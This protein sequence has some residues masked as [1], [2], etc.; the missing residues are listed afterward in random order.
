MAEFNQKRTRLAQLYLEGLEDISG[1]DLPQIPEYD[2]I[3]AW[4][5]FVIKV[6]ALNRDK[7]MNRLSDYN[8]GYG[9]HFPPTHA[10]SYV[11]EKYAPSIGLLPETE[12]AADKIISL[13]LFPDMQDKDAEYVCK[14]IKEIMK[15]G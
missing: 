9:L 13:P 12:R 5:L 15:N 4:H 14:A 8:I 10:L 7:F 3:H 6:L 2:H 1:I 11:K